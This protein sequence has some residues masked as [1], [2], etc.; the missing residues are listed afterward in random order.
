[1]APG[2]RRALEEYVDLEYPI[3]LI[4]DPEGGY[5]I[6]FP[7]LPGCMTQVDDPEE[8]WAMAEDAK[9]TWMEGTYEDGKDIPLP[10]YPEQASGKFLVRVRPSLHRSLAEEA[11]RAGVSLN[12][13]VAS[14][15]AERNAQVKMERQL[16]EMSAQL[17]EMSAQLA[18][19]R[20]Q[21]RHRGVVRTGRGQGR[22]SLPGAGDSGKEETKADPAA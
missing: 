19:V 3:N 18:E 6:E 1:M 16:A 20:G 7:D 2:S 12:H 14:L 15:L 5:V 4:A 8:I 17:A 22:A 21:L 11:K 9:R 10:S 13:Y